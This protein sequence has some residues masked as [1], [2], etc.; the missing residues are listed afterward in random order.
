MLLASFAAFQ[1]ASAQVEAC[2]PRN[3]QGFLCRTVFDLT[4]NQ[5]AAEIADAF[6]VPVRIL[7]TII[8]AYLTVRIS[9]FVIRRLVNRLQHEDTARRIS[10]FRRKTGIAL[11]DT[12]P[13]PELRRAQR[14]E[15]LSIVLR[16]VASVVIWTIAIFA[17][18]DAL[19]V[20]AAALVAGAGVIGVAIGFGAQ[21]LVRDFLNGIFIVMED[22]YGVGDV[23]DAGAAVGTVEGVSLRTTRL[24]DVSGIV[25][26][27]PNGQI[28]RVG[29]QSQQWSR[30]L[31]D[32]PIA[33]HADVAKAIGL[34]KAAAD[35]LAQDPRF[36][37]S[38]LAE[39]EIWGVD[40]VAIDKIVLRVVVKTRPLEQWRVARELRGRVLRSFAVSGIPPQSPDGEE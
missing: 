25:W 37:A 16:S 1:D 7:V 15:T 18:L 5:R 38:V 28:M 29:N 13:T 14:T 8:V 24:R 4:D 6:A 17:V 9:R 31:L 34:V 23:I 22:Q 20:N 36:R 32:I 3:E 30:A 21:N 10:R 26:H 11:L 33:P 2:G 35:D 40:D 39:P 12:S 19:G 27:I